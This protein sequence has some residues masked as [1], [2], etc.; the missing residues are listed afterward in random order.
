MAFLTLQNGRK[1]YYTEEGSG[2]P[3]VLI[4]GWRS[5]ADRY[6][7]ASRLLAADGNYRCIR[8]DQCGHMRSEVPSEP[9]TLKTLADDLH[10]IITQMKLEKPILVGHSMGGMTILEY[11]RHYGC[12][13]LDR[14]VIVDIP[15]RKINDADWPYLSFGKYLSVEDAEKSVALMQNDFWEAIR[16]HSINLV[17][18]FSELPKAEQDAFLKERMLGQDPGVLTSLWTSF[19]FRDHRDVLPKIQCPTAI[20]YAEIRPCCTGEMAQYYLDHIPAPTMAVC[21]EGATHSIP[22]QQPERFAAESL[23]FFRTVW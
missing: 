4:H 6:E 21:F 19:S 14:I 23:K 18:G 8:Y 10:E 7:A 13:H 20:F 16:N 5:N 9:P 12:E 3:V 11:I 15:P 1:L 22:L 17:P 2:R